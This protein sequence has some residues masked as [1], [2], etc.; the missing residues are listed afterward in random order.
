MNS[1]DVDGVRLAVHGDFAA[2]TMVFQ[3]G[4]C[5]AAAQP[6][7][8][9]PPDSGFQMV[10]MEC[11][12]HGVS[13]AGP[14]DQLSIARFSADLIALIDARAMAPVVIG[15]I[16]MGAAI[17]SRIAVIRPD[18]VAG[19]VLARPAWLIDPAPPNLQPNALAGQLMLNDPATARAQFDASDI[20]RTL[21]QTSPDNLSSIR[22]FFDRGP[23]DITAQLL[24]RIARDG[25][26][27]SAAQ[28]ASI[29]VPTLIIGTDRD[30]VHPLD[31]AHSLAALIPGAQLTTVTA[32]STDA[33]Q[34]RHEFQAALSHFLK[35]IP[36]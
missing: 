29:A 30:F 11:R 5:G 34:Y 36:L 15:G 22:S 13:E 16:S 27:M 9:F 8:V 33:S 17:A 3:H 1:F 4:L 26:G 19:L 6:R 35:E 10:T 2:R 21:Q 14:T 31:Y 25:P 7:E 28:L 12:G 23:L 20:A 32:K 24:S 18:L